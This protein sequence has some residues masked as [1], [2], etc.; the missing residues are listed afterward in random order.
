MNPALIVHKDEE[1]NKKK[2]NWE[3]SKMYLHISL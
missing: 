1:E 3:L 2:S